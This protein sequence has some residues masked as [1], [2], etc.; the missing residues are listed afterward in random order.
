MRGTEFGSCLQTS[1]FLLPISPGSW[2][3][4]IYADATGFI[5]PDVAAAATTAAFP[6]RVK[7]PP[8]RQRVAKPNRKKN[9]RNVQTALPNRRIKLA[10]T[11][12]LFHIVEKRREEKRRVP[13]SFVN[14]NNKKKMSSWSRF[15]E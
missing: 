12:R 11:T 3:K 4:F 9:L 7:D 2:S 5:L 10:K 6:K 1:S 13:F 15:F 8:P 14:N